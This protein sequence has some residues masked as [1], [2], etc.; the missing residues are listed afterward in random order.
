MPSELDLAALLCSR[1]CHDLIS[2]ISALNNGMEVL[3]DED[4]PEMR[5]HALNLIEMSGRQASI[6]LQFARM[7]YGASSTAA[8]GLDLEEARALLEN[9]FSD[10][11]VRLEWRAPVRVADKA[12]VKVLLNLALIARDAIPR[13]G[14][15]AIVAAFE[16]EKC[17][18]TLTARGEKA[19][20]SED[21]QQALRGQIPHD[22]LDARSIVPFYTH[23]LAS[24]CGL[25]LSLHEAEGEVTLSAAPS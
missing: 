20:V 10:G 23:L 2:P 19:G 13:G 25:E 9:M 11:K 24:S 6:K 8:E 15:L 3:S 22:S 16:G 12:L 4:D 1:I 18:L 14:E 5:A 17:S 7:A 21:V